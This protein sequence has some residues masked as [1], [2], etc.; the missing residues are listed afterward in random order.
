MSNPRASEASRGIR[1]RRNDRERNVL[2]LVM[3]ALDRRGRAQLQLNELA[4][5]AQVSASTLVRRYGSLLGLLNAADQCRFQAAST[6]TV[7]GV[8][9]P[10]ARAREADAV[11]A[12]LDARLVGAERD[13]LQDAIA[14]V[15]APLKPGRPWAEGPQNETRAAVVRAAWALLAEHGS[16]AV[17]LAEVARR[18]GMREP[19]IS[20]YFR[21]RLV[22]LQEAVSLAWQTLQLLLQAV[23][24]QL[25]AG[26]HRWPGTL[27]TLLLHDRAAIALQRLAPDDAIAIDSRWAAGAGLSDQLLERL[28]SAG[29]A[30]VGPLALVLSFSQG[31]LL[32]RALLGADHPSVVAAEALAARALL[33]GLLALTPVGVPEV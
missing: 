32:R 25:A 16:S 17:V 30:L 18:V 22:V 19:A 13:A 11:G 31:Q 6:L 26:D 9:T 5:E 3:A 2:T 4:D 12:W 14:L 33:P 10:L 20:Y 7:G 15:A 27:L 29:D 1:D 21:A 24:E 28:R 23:A 8:L